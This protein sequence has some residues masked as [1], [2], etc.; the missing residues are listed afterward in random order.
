MDKSPTHIIELLRAT[1]SIKTLTSSLHPS[2]ESRLQFES[3]RRFLDITRHI[4]RRWPYS[5]PYLLAFNN[6]ILLSHV[7]EQFPF[8]AQQYSNVAEG[9]QALFKIA[10]AALNNNF[11]IEL[12][13]YEDALTPHASYYFKYTTERPDTDRYT[14]LPYD[15]DSFYLSLLF[16][17]RSFAPNF[18]YRNLIPEPGNI[19]KI[20]TQ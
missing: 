20:H 14:T 16:Y 6:D 1:Y 19:Y 3:T 5:T 9:A 13:D 17:G 10:V 18:L 12:L 11:Y 15:L 4:H 8:K 7:F 2:K